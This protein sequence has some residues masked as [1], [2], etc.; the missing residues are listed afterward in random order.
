M[1]YL[2]S[3]TPEEK[4]SWVENV[5]ARI[6][7]VHGVN[8]RNELDNLYKFPAGTTNTLISKGSFKRI[9]DL[10]LTVSMHFNVSLDFLLLGKQEGRNSREEFKPII[11]NAVFKAMDAGIISGDYQSIGNTANVILDEVFCLN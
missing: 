4:R 3:L 8:H 10:A 11:E 6:M 2:K 1:L 5:V 9:F 7:D